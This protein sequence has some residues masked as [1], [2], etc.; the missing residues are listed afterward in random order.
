MGIFKLKFQPNRLPHP[1]APIQKRTKI[2]MYRR[3]IRHDDI[4]IKKT[5]R[6]EESILVVYAMFFTYL[7]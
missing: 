5:T 1:R 2:M 3:L 6:K 4:M 7:P